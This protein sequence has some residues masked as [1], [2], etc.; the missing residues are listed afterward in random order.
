MS[1]LI[2]SKTKDFNR[3]LGLGDLSAFGFQ[4]IKSYDSQGNL[5][6]E[7][8]DRKS[9]MPY[10][11]FKETGKSV[12]STGE[13]LL[14]LTLKDTIVYKSL[15]RSDMEHDTVFFETLLTQDY[16]KDNIK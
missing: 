4:K 15:D 9:F 2:G 13:Y 5:V 8:V 11:V 3:I 12:F 14:K 1:I 6:E 16:I 7:K 10:L